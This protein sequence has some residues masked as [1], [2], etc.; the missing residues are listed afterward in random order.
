L[1]KP[2]LLLPAQIAHSLGPLALRAYGRIKPY[3]TLTWSPKTWRGLEFT[4][5]LGIAGG[6]DKTGFASPHG[7]ALA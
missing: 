3:K 6:V 4:N 7:G 2:W 1:V 5:P